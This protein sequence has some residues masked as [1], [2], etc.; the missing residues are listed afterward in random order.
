MWRLKEKSVK[1]WLYESQTSS[2]RVNKT[3]L[4]AKAQHVQ[5]A[6]GKESDTKNK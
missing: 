3:E 6:N 5:F 1:L 2:V 4:W